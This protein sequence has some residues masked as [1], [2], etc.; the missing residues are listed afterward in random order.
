MKT[1]SNR[2]ATSVVRTAPI[3]L[4]RPVDSDN[5]ARVCA[6][7][8]PGGFDHVELHPLELRQSGGC[9]LAPTR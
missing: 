3:L 6:Q 9:A 7:G 4:T 5:E 8:T 2:A 1:D